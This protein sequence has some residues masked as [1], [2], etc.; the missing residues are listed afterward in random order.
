MLRTRY[1]SMFTSVMPMGASSNT[2][3]NCASP[4]RSACSTSLWRVT[5]RMYPSRTRVPSGA[6]PTARPCSDTQRTSPSART[7]RYSSR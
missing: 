3:R 7:S 6:V 1:P 4:V 5:S 2:A